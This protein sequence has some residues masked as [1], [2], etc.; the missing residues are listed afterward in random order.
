MLQL[1]A[2]VLQAVL[3]PGERRI[4][5]CPNMKAYTALLVL[6]SV[7]FS[8][9][10]P[11]VSLCLA[12]KTRLLIFIVVLFSFPISFQF[13][14]ASTVNG[15]IWPTDDVKDIYSQLF[16]LHFRI[17]WEIMHYKSHKSCCLCWNKFVN[18]IKGAVATVPLKGS[19]VKGLTPPGIKSS[20][21][22]PFHSR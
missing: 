20:S 16:L 13:R 19:K 17:H 11:L 15:K 4:Y 6:F 9:V 14:V 21:P 2:P 18:K 3:L 5:T 7:Y 1:S 22:A 12:L 10:S 8:S